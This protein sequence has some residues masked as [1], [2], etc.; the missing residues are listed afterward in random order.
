MV[1]VF[2]T[3]FKSVST[4]LNDVDIKDTTQYNEYDG[5]QQIYVSRKLPTKITG[6]YKN[7]NFYFV[8][9]YYP[10][11]TNELSGYWVIS[12]LIILLNGYMYLGNWVHCVV[13]GDS[14]DKHYMALQSNRQ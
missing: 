4:R 11:S 13:Y 1:S 14:K 2:K 12:L 5:N 6:E 8:P 3:M 10:V 7:D 9:G